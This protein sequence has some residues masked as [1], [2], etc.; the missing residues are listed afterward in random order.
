MSESKTFT[1]QGQA[2]TLNQDDVVRALRGVRPDPIRKYYIKVGSTA[3]PIKQALAEATGLSLA[4]FNAQY[5]FRVL[6]NLGFEV[7]ET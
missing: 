7:K 5:A 6:Q 3:Y 1:I 2:F 4:A